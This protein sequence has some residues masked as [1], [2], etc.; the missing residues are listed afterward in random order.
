MSRSSFLTEFHAQFGLP[1]STVVGLVEQATGGR[2]V[3]LERVVR[4][5]ENEVYRVEL[6]DGPVV[7]GR[8]RVPG[9]V[10]M[11]RE[12]WAMDQARRAGVPVPEVLSLTTLATGAGDRDAMVVA[13]A[14]GSQLASLLP[15]LSWERRRAVMVG[16]G[17]VMA[18]LHTI[19]VPGLSRPDEGGVW[20]DPVAHRRSRIE[21]RKAQRDRLLGAGISPG[22]VDQ[23]FA[24]LDC[25]LDEAQVVEPVLCHGDV[26][27]EHVFVD[28]DLRVSAVID[29]GLWSGGVPVEDLA[30]I[31]MHQTDSDFG[32]VVEGYGR[33]RLDDPFF[34]EAIRQSIVERS[35]GAIAWNT[36]IGHTEAVAAMAAVLRR[37]LANGTND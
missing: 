33:Y 27:P 3:D 21:D 26:S 35:I 10:G 15:S 34:G 16:I 1:R 7:F 29:W 31:A 17:E 19:G 14:P 25:L 6:V 23:A 4:G 22:E 5:D 11:R 9:G 32:A 30:W 37:A 12:V 28:E 36:S 24:L 2:V 20:P 8:I 18:R 13:E